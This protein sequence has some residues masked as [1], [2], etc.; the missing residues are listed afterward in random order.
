M[1]LIA[2][3][4][5]DGKYLPSVPRGDAITQDTW[6]R[7]AATELGPVWPVDGSAGEG[8][9][10]CDVQGCLYRAYGKVAALV[11]EGEAIADDCH[12]VDLLVSPVAAHRACWNT[13]IIDRLDTYRK[14]GHA[15]WF[16][17]QGITIE[18][19]RDWQGHRL[20]SPRQNSRVGPDKPAS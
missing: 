9:L 15:V 3:R 17:V 14:G 12:M 7:R 20:W 18:T 6:T 11:R 5:P 19:V 10:Q 16:D 13:P 8:S 4:A 1:R 2:V